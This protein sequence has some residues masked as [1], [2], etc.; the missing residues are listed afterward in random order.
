VDGRRGAAITAIAAYGGCLAVSAVLSVLDGRARSILVFPL[1]LAFFWGFALLIGSVCG[2]IFGEPPEEWTRA[3]MLLVAVCAAITAAGLIALA[4]WSDSAAITYGL[5]L[6][7][8]AG[9]WVCLGAGMG[10]IFGSLPEIGM[11][12][13][14]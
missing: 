1:G 3:G 10:A 11:A 12:E 5:G 13:G 8:G 2:V 7:G 4:N 14:D 9:A 6:L